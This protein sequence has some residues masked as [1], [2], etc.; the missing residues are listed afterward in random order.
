MSISIL[1]SG[2]DEIGRSRSADAKV[3]GAECQ[4]S[5]MPRIRE[6]W[7]LHQGPLRFL[8]SVPI[9]V[10]S[11]ARQGAE[12][13]RVETILLPVPRL[14]GCMARRGVETFRCTAILLPVQCEQVRMP[15]QGVQMCRIATILPPVQLLRTH[16]VAR[17]G[18]EKYR[19]A[20]NLLLV[21]RDGVERTDA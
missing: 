1:K 11:K 2:K 14:E 15:R 9:R 19:N 12:T 18:V 17:Q 20:M 6:C 4:S 8:P 21:P 10:S 5:V 16:G 3:R 7:C 13:F